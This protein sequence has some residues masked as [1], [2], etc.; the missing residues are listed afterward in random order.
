M[1][2]ITIYKVIDRDDNQHPSYYKGIEQL[3]DFGKDRIFNGWETNTYKE[4][5]LDDDAK[6][7]DFLENDYG[8]DIS[9]IAQVS[10]SDFKKRRDDNQ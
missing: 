5:D 8:V 3:R 10:L 1:N 6:L 7:F 2:Y 9:V 4:G